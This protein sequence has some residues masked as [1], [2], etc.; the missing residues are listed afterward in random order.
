MVYTRAREALIDVNVTIPASVTG[1]AR[2][3]VE[4]Q[5]VH[6]FPMHAWVGNTFKEI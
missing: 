1:V 4:V 6:A 2:A 3:S 5:I